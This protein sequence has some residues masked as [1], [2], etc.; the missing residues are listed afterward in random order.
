MKLT[1][2]VLGGDGGPIDD[3]TVARLVRLGRAVAERE[4]R[5]LVSA[6]PGLAEAAVQGARAAGGLVVGISPARSAAE[7]V[8]RYG[9]PADAFDVLIY[10][11]VGLKGHEVAIIRSSDIVIVAGGRSGPPD[12]LAIAYDEG[13]PIG[14]LT[15]THGIADAVEQLMRVCAKPNSAVVLCDDGPVQ[16]VDRLIDHHEARHSKHPSCPTG[17][18]GAPVTPVEATG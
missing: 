12:D 7:H 2:G 8:D 13:R 17:P 6:C 14:V 11:A 18:T 9:P 3:E 10:T 5:L 4:C 16:L 1:I 15:R